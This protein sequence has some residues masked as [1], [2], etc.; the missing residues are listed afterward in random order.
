MTD[1]DLREVCALA[2]H[3][4]TEH[5]RAHLAQWEV[6]QR[7]RQQSHLLQ[8]WVDTDYPSLVTTLEAFRTIPSQIVEYRF[9]TQRLRALTTPVRDGGIAEWL[10]ARLDENHEPAHLAEIAEYSEGGRIY[11]Q[12]ARH[13]SALNAAALL[14]PIRIQRILGQLESAATS[15][16]ELQEREFAQWQQ[17]DPEY[18]MRLV[19][20]WIADRAD[21]WPWQLDLVRWNVAFQSNLDMLM[22]TVTLTDFYQQLSRLAHS[23]L[24]TGEWARHFLSWHQVMTLRLD[25]LV[26]A[27]DQQGGPA[28][29]FHNT[30]RDRVADAPR[31]PD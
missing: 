24:L 9:L 31:H 19:F 18:P 10:R 5:E 13:G 27:V 2:N 29:Y 4:R 26:Q 20:P 25:R 16:P 28:A 22:D 12:L 21:E 23:P 15:V 30:G 17:V 1:Q 3:L 8:R 14:E 11:S 7:R 6:E